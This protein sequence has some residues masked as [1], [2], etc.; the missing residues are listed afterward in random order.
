MHDLTPNIDNILK[1]IASAF[2]GIAG[3][4][5]TQ[6]L[7]LAKSLEEDVDRHMAT[8]K[9]FYHPQ[10]KRE[11]YENLLTKLCEFESSVTELAYMEFFYGYIG[12]IALNAGQFEKAMQYA[13]AGIEVCE[14]QQSEDGVSS[15]KML[16]CDIAL[17]IGSTFHAHRLFREAQPFRMV[18]FIAEASP[19]DDAIFTKL[20]KSKKRP[21]TYRFMKDK[22]S[23][24][25][26]SKTRFIMKQMRVSRQTAQR[27]L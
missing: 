10:Y 16:L 22:D 6:E 4:I 14:I 17:S 12:R 7:A 9:G 21:P 13:L 27:Y 26:E 11:S 24:E 15:N 5:N 23:M 1:D 3:A 19:D 25:K 2:D 8:F 18:P 20:L